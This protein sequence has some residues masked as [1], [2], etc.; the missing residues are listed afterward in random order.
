MLDLAKAKRIS[1]LSLSKA[2]EAVQALREA[3]LSQE[4]INHHVRAVKGFSRWLWSDGRAASITWPT[5]RQQARSPTAD[6]STT[7]DPRGSRQDRACRGEMAPK[8][9][10]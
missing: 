8:L 1:D 4:T 7:L 6:T 3:G 5:W 2:L 9:A 10:D